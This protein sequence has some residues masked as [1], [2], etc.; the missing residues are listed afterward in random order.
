MVEDI[1]I[2]NPLNL[3]NTIQSKPILLNNKI[4]GIACGSFHS[5]FIYENEVYKSTN[6]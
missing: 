2:N 4:Q 3:L 6:G 5:Y 1:I